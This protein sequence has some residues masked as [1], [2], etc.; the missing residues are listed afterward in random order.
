MYLLA[1]IQI[2]S[3]LRAHLSQRTWHSIHLVSYVLL[4]VTTIHMLTAGTDS[5]TVIPETVAIL[6]GMG[7]VFGTVLLLTW[8]A[9]AARTSRGRPGAGDRA[10]SACQ[11]ARR[12][13]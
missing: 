9:S 2:T 4:G 11:R 7:A 1:T 6:M 3:L 12:M 10:G 13:A 5:T 8:R